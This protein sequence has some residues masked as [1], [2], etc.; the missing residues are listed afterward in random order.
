MQVNSEP[1][2]RHELVLLPTSEVEDQ[3]DDVARRSDTAALGRDG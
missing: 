2:T 1:V 3:R